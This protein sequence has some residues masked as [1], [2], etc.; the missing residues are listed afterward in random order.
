M[1][2]LLMLVAILVALGCGG[3][4][5]GDDTTPPVEPP[6]PPTALRVCLEWDPVVH[7]DLAGYTIYY[8]KVSSQ[9]DIEI[10][11]EEPMTDVCIE[12][13]SYF[14]E[15]MDYYFVATAF[16]FEEESDYSNEV[17]WSP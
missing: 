1:K 10:D 8:G 14:T 6:P 11:I 2:K 17:V 5:S 3:G 7:P 9:Y 13:E 12:D 4:G 16:S 15:G